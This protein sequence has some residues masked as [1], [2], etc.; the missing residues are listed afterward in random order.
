MEEKSR[1]NPWLGLESYQEG[2]I[3]YGRDDDI[4]DLTQSV[5][6]DTDTLLYGK[7][8][9]GK[10]S[11]LNAG[12]IPA[13]RRYGYLPVLIRLSHKGGFSY[14]HQIKEAIAHATIP[15]PTDENGNLVTLSQEEQTAR[16]Q[17]LALR[18]REVVACKDKDKETLYEYF[19]RHTFHDKDGERINLLII[20][21]QFEEIFTL[22]KDSAT[23]KRFFAE[24]ANFLNDI[25]PD[26]LQA[27]VIMQS[28][29]QAEVTV[30]D[31]DNI[32]DLLDDLILTSG[33]DIPE[34]VT[35][36]TIHL[37]FT[38]R[39]DFLSEFEYYSTTI[40][41]LKQNRYG[42]RPINEEQAS[43]IILRPVPGLISESVARLIIENVTGRDDFR[44]DGVPEIEVDSAV[45]SLYLNRLYNA[46]EGDVIT[47]ELVEQKGGEIISNFYNDAISVISE[48][49]V[50]Y[51]EDRLLNGQGRR[52]NI[53]VYDAIHEGNVTEKELD[54]LCNK[55]KILRQFNYAGD[56][57][58]EYV[59]DILCPVVKAH[60]DERVLLKQQEAERE[61]QEA[62]HEAL[63]RRQKEELEK[64]EREARRQ[65][66]KIRMR[67]NVSLFLL[68]AGIVTW[69]I[70]FFFNRMTFKESYADFTVR[71]GWPEGIGK[72]LSD[73]EKGQMPVYY[74]LVRYGYNK[75]NTRVNVLNSQK[76]PTRNKFDESPLVGLY[77]TDG[78]DKQAKD[79]AIL[80]RQTAYW[81]YTSDNNN[82]VFRKTAYGMNGEELYSIQ[83]FRSSSQSMNG[84]TADAA[85]NW[86]WANYIN[87]AGQSLRIRDNGADR[88]RI[89]VNDS[90][91]YYESYRFFNETGTPQP[92]H[93]D[94]Y[95]YRYVLGKDGRILQK[96]PVDVFGDPIED[97]AITYEAFDR[98][99]RWLQASAGKAEYHS[100]MVVF[101]MKERTD[102]LLFGENGELKYRSETMPDESY[103]YFYEKGKRMDVAHYRIEN[104]GRILTYQEQI[105][106]RTNPNVQQTRYFY[107][108]S[109]MPYRIKHE[110]T[111][112]NRF[113]V[114]YYGGVLPSRIDTPIYEGTYHK[115]VVDTLKEEGLTKVIKEYLDMNDSLSLLCEYNRDVAYY[116]DK[117]EM[118]KHVT[119]KNDSICYAYLNEYENGEIVAQ[120]VMGV[121]GKTPVRYPKMEMEQL[122]YYKMKYI[123][124]FSGNLVAIKGVNEFGEESLITIIKDGELFEYRLNVLPSQLFGKEERGDCQIFGT[125]M[126]FESLHKI[127]RANQVEYIR[128]SDMQGTWYQ[129]GIKNGDLLINNPAATIVK[130]ARPNP[131][132]NT[133]DILEFAIPKGE[134]GIEHYP[135]YFN[136]KEM[137]RYNNAIHK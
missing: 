1:K 124:N 133:Y 93:M 97:A 117:N 121:D 71:Y 73:S 134:K 51:L 123:R 77:E 29:S 6:N 136:Q 49:A 111:E 107:A 104:E 128:I 19:H 120:S 4:R 22:Q 24:L 62:E 36:N 2:E 47:A 38:I 61:R 12:V 26:E 79:F 10:S 108:D 18:I 113:F 84:G 102:S 82:N 41:S 17:E 54:I 44:L 110:E 85:G 122:C 60:K 129:S 35:D 68:L 65:R 118:I 59:H 30:F 48:S 46:K 15:I 78:N 69:T 96:I 101:T 64:V 5:L 42:L 80:Q 27:D 13:A 21:D 81:I 130:V 9:I 94:V 37:V 90:T 34:Y 83:F 125:Q 7:S 39:E 16:E 112:G 89:M 91:G 116:N 99:G 25:M 132:K 87:S 131:E 67:L 63:V 95:G 98:F 31:A 14:L 88:M 127:D 76:Q 3:L 105:L 33:N 50:E 106:P 11:I 119:Y 114:A 100:R 126:Y 57:R 40:P 43:Q 58:I 137:K 20:F 70:W 109:I 28:D 45:L 75:K 74:Q 92:N 103:S 135:V 72:K 53:T 8:G 86:V 52:D 66:K 32:D 55:K 56:L 23:K 115:M